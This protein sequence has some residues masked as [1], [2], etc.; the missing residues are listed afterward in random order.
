[1]NAPPRPYVTIGL[2]ISVALM[3]GA[4]GGSAESQSP[5]TDGSEDA[6]QLRIGLI[7]GAN[8]EWGSCMEGGVESATAEHGV[9]L[10]SANSDSDAAKELANVEDMISRGVDAILLNTVS[11]DAL[12]GGVQK[13]AAAGVPIYLIAVVPENPDQ[14][15]GATVV[16]LGESGSLAAGWIADDAAGADATA[17]VIAGAP[18]AASDL[19]VNGFKDALPDNVDVVAEQPGMYNRAKAMEVAENVIEAHPDLE[20]AF[21]LNED[22]AFGVSAAFAAAGREDVKIV[23]QNGTEPGLAA[24]ESGEFAATVSD[25]AASLGAASVENAVALLEGTSEEKIMKMP[26]SLINEDNL[27]EAVPFCSN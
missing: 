7:N 3:I 18:G 1:M 27:D 17:A 11:V 21:V 9:E 6:E 25:S 23:T 2:T 10:F 19:T 26:L 13:A 5:G 24:V 15:L 20:Y 22:M 12:E 4:C 16:D 14:V 8:N